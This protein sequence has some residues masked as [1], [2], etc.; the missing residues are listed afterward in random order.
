MIRMFTILTLSLLAL[1]SCTS[2]SSYDPA[3]Q[4]SPWHGPKDDP[5][6]HPHKK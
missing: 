5:S 2:S 6:R 1:S 4:L 3:S